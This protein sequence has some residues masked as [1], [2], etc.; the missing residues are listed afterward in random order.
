MLNMHAKPATGS[1]SGK[2]AARRAEPTLD[3]W[4]SMGLDKKLTENAVHSRKKTGKMMDEIYADL[5]PYVE[6]TLWP[7]WLIGKVK[8]LGINGLQIQGYGSPGL[9]T[10]DSGA[11]VYEI[12]KRDASVCTLVGAHNFIGL[13]VINALGDEEQKARLLPP[14]INFEKVYSF[15]LTEPDNGSDASDLK[16]TARK[17]EGGYI[18]NGQKRWIGNATLGD[19]IIWAKNIDDGNRIQAFLCEKGSA[20][21][22]PKKQEG[23][24]ALRVT[25]NADITLTNCFVPDRNKLT[26]ATDFATGTNAILEASRV[27]IAWMA[28]GIAAGAYEAALKYCLNR[29][30]FGRPIAKF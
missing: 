3:I 13:A 11:M 23:K 27:M 16:T 26:K 7:A 1:N 24:M 5:L 17:V 6:S 29:V 28:C 14:G 12:A 22:H 19:C 10:L 25:Q 2:S 18:L 8:S 30:Q 21:Y 15:G 9:C 20:G 4:E